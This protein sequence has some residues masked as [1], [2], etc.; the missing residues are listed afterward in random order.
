MIALHGLLWPDEIRD[1]TPV[2]PPQVQPDEDEIDEA[3]A[4]IEARA[5]DDLT[6]PEFTDRY[7]EAMHTVI[8]AKPED[9]QLPEAPEPEA[10][11]RQLLDLMAAQLLVVTWHLEVRAGW[12]PR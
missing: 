8:E 11:P 3:V 5:L 9:R 10:R 6:G 12:C 7:T 4:L 2:V 1:P